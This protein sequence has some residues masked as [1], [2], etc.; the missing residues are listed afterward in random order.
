M[1]RTCTTCTHPHR[2]E[3]DRRL[4]DGAPLRN[5]TKQFSLSSA[6]LFRHNKHISKVLSNARQEAE[7]LRADGLMEHL[8]HLTSEAARLKRKAEQAKDYRTALAGVREMS[9]L[10]ELVMRLA[11]EMQERKSEFDFDGRP[12]EQLSDVELL[13]ILARGQGVTE[14]KFLR[15]ARGQTPEGSVQSEI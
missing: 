1:P 12:L 6:S 11:V 14:T 2:D 15:I 3:I 8:N 5:I 9:R 10:L 4:L 7:I 13:Q